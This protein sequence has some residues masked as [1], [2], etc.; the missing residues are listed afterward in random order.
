[1]Q[2]ERII[3]GQPQ[4][5]DE[6]PSDAPAS[7]AVPLRVGGKVIGAINYQRRA[8]WGMWDEDEVTGLRILSEQLSQALD[9]ARLLQETRQ[10]A[11]REQQIND[12]ATMLTNS[13]DIEAMLRATVQELGQLPGVLEASVHIDLPDD[14]SDAAQITASEQE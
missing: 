10:Q 4:S 9:S 3:L 11:M 13:V 5:P 8:E 1:M 12:V 14:A 6:A 2:D 7:V